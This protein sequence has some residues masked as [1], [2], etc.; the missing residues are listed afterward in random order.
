M[1]SPIADCRGF[2][3]VTAV[4]MYSEKSSDAILALRNGG[5]G[6]RVADGGRVTRRER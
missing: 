2:C 4:Y 1:A 3:V 5:T 6:I